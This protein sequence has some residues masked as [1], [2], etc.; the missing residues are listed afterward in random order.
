MNLTLIKTAI[1]S[2]VGRGI[3]LA[4]K[5]SPTA[6][7]VGG[8]IGLVAT[9]VL[10]SKETLNLES[11]VDTAAVALAKNYAPALIVGSIS[12]ACI[13]GGYHILNTRHVALVDAYIKTFL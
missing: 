5:H 1:T 12:V 4:K 8:T 11:I 7:V 3:L 13:L 10:A 6:M 2:K 9:V